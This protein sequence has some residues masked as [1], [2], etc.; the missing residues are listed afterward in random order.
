MLLLYEQRVYYDSMIA[1]IQSSSQK[2]RIKQWHI[3]VLVL[4]SFSFLFVFFSRYHWP[5]ATIRLGE[6]RLFVL[7][8]KTPYHQYR[9][10]SE[11]ESLAPYQGMLFV[12]SDADRH[13]FV[14]RDMKFSIDII[15]LLDGKVVDIAPSLPLEPD[16]TNF[17]LTRYYPRENATMVLEVPAG[18][19][20][21]HGITIGDTL[22]VV[23]R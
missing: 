17:T 15:W 1:N 12:F 14:M 10:L 13:I 3:I 7:V 18:W 16:A 5:K 9:G 20:Q 21:E 22:T 6:E 8:A 2:P 23:D 4:F 19:T 11:R